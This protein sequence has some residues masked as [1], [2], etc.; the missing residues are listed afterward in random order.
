MP[1]ID[2]IEPG[3]FCWVEC[4]TSDHEVASGFY[5]G[6]FGWEAQDDAV[7]NMGIYTTFLKNGKKVAALF[8]DDSMPPHW[9]SYVSVA[10]A[11]TAAEKATAAG[12]SVVAPPFDV[13]EHGRMCVIQDP[14]GAIVSAWEPRAHAGW[15]LAYE[16]QTVVWNELMTR[17]KDKAIAFYQ[18]V[19]GWKEGQNPYEASD[20]P[21]YT[22]FE[23]GGQSVGGAMEMGD[24]MPAEVPP[25]WGLYFGVDDPDAIAAKA[26]E[27]GGNVTF[28][29]MDTPA[30][31]MAGLTDPTGA[32]FAV[33]KMAPPPEG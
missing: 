24:M 32:A 3:S 27:L 8:K 33:I 13:L 23:C 28:P 15:E 26:Q 5:T 30:G 25:N 18:E 17:G 22:V 21:D 11:D 31:R 2:K 16:D 29:A 1:D 19:F 6:L 14:T 7:E 20:G 12:G 9:N 10:S 4:V